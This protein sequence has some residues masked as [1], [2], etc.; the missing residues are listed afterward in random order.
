M[1]TNT[2]TDRAVNEV[3]AAQILGLS[4]ATLRKMR[5]LGP[6]D[7]GLKSIPFFRYSAR[8]IRYS[9][10]D[11]EAWRAEYRTEQGAA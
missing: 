1:N 2:T 3:E 9:V 4:P 6:Q 8:C 10:A 7:T 5:S 11:L